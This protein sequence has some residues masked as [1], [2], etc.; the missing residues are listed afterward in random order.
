MGTGGRA[1]SQL[2]INQASQKRPLGRSQLLL[3]LSYHPQSQGRCSV[4]K[5]AAWKPQRALGL[6]GGPLEKHSE[7]QLSSLRALGSQ[8]GKPKAKQFSFLD[9]RKI[10]YLQGTTEVF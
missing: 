10:R 6:Q 1:G 8:L 9:H 5:G 4:H 2:G 7:L 3:L